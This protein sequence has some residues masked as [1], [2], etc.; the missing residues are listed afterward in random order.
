MVCSCPF[1]HVAIIWNI[2]LPP[3]KIAWL[4][5]PS[6]PQN[7]AQPVE[8][9]DGQVVESVHRSAS[10][11]SPLPL[12][13]PLRLLP[14]RWRCHVG[15]RPLF[16]RVLASLVVRRVGTRLVAVDAEAGSV[17]SVGSHH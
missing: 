15:N 8:K 5:A 4:F 13:Q 10:L 2:G 1:R 9:V 17:V 3:V 6:N 11:A 14:E 12:R 7:L 16:R